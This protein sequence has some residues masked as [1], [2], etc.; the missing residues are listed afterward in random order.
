MYGK[1]IMFKV[2]IWWKL[3]VRYLSELDAVAVLVCLLFNL[4]FQ[5]ERAKKRSFF[6]KNLKKKSSGFL[7]CSLI[8]L[9]KKSSE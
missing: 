7:L 5:K 8:F 3:L 2:Q 9:L 4:F 6:K 1:K